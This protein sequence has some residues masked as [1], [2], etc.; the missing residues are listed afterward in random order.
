MG[1]MVGD[2]PIDDGLSPGWCGR[3]R[4]RVEY[5]KVWE[6]YLPTRD[7]WIYHLEEKAFL[8]GRILKAQEYS[9]EPISR[10]AREMGL[11]PSTVRSFLVDGDLSRIGINRLT[12]LMRHAEEVTDDGYHWVPKEANQLPWMLQAQVR[13]DLGL[14]SA[15]ES[16][17]YRGDK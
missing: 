8:R 1:E 2:L 7:T 15:R 9:G 13:P 4:L 3:G 5:L 6:S 10:M 12:T 16:Y 11:N 17:P 14:P